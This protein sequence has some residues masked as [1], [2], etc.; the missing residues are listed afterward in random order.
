MY[1]HR[2]GKLK[3]SNKPHKAGGHTSNRELNRGTHGRVEKDRKEKQGGQQVVPG[4][5]KSVKFM[6]L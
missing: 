4:G 2:A 3:Q 5:R 1:H 6:D